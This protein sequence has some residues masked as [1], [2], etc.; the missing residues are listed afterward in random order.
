LPGAECSFI[1]L[2]ELHRRPAKTTT[3]GMNQSSQ[4]AVAASRLEEKYKARIF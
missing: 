3:A 2:K 1:E 4:H